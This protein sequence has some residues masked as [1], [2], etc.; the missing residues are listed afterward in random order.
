M[1]AQY[2]YSGYTMTASNLAP[3]SYMLA[4]F[5]HRIA[6]GQ[7]APAAT[8]NITVLADTHMYIDIPAEGAHVAQPFDVGGWAIDGGAAKGTGVDTIHI[9]FYDA[10]GAPYQHP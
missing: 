7:W 9:W 10:N 8:R 3:G 4:V 1:G 5:A 6:D 2:N